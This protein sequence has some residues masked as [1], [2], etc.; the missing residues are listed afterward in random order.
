M[1]RRMVLPGRPHCHFAGALL[2]SFIGVIYWCQ[3]RADVELCGRVVSSA[4][5]G[6]HGMSDNLHEAVDGLRRRTL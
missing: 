1:S 3:P 4:R 6:I 2:A 5:I